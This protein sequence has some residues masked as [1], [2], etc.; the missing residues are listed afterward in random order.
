MTRSPPPGPSRRPLHS[1]ARRACPALSCALAA[2]LLT[3]SA[4]TPPP[5]PTEL[6]SPGPLRAR[7]LRLLD[8]TEALP[9]EAEWAP[10]GPAALGE[11]LGLVRDP[12]TPETQ[13]TR[14]VAALAVVA[15]PEAAAQLEALLRD[16]S[17]PI[18]LRAAAVFALGRR[19]GH[20]ALPALSPLLRDG[21]EQVRASAARALGRL[22][23]SEARKVLE[24][25][26]ALEEHPT[27][28][29]ALQQGLCDN[30]P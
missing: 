18:P 13:R 24:E 26:L 7:V 12:E 2:W 11:L 30:Q 5:S 21:S 29:E 25:Q 17:T 16:P 8:A 28:R 1:L 3:A 19:A 6:R 9:R 14:A 22:G 20:S 10:L 4:A 23:G 15:H 27:V